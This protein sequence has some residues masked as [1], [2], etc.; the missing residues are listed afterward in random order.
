MHEQKFMFYYILDNDKIKN[1]Y[2]NM[3]KKNK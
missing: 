1:L 3:D 2:K